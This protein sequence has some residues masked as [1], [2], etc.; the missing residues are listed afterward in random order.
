MAYSDDEEDEDE[1]DNGVD[2]IVAS[3]AKKQRMSLT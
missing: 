2:D 1:T 3:P